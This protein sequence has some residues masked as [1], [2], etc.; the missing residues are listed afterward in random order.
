MRDDAYSG[1]LTCSNMSELACHL[2]GVQ[3]SVAL[4]LMSL[5]EDALSC[6]VNMQFE[7]QKSCLQF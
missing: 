7:F 5:M 4:A 3:M 2:M 6:H 1:V